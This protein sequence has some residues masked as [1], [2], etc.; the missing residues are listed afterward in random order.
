MERCRE[1]GRE[2]GRKEQGMRGFGKY[3]RLKK[4]VRQVREYVYSKSGTKNDDE[5][6]NA[7]EKNNGICH[8]F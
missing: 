4:E 1:K 6:R 2:E 3:W 7:V 5:L 8:L